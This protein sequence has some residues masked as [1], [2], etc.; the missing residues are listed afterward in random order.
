AATVLSQRAMGLQERLVAA[1][2]EWSGRFVGLVGADAADLMCASTSLAGEILR[3]YEAK[4]E[5][6]LAA[7]IGESAVAARC[8][9][10]GV[11]AGEAAHLLHATAQGLKRTSTT[12]PEFVKGMTVAVRLFCAPLARKD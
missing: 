8:Q 1:C 12:R 2:D 4:F 5:Q 10:A 11:C 6:A 9:S 3:E 7:A